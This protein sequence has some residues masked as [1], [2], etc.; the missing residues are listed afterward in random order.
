MDSSVDLEEILNKFIKLIQYFANYDEKLLKHAAVL[1]NSISDRQRD[2]KNA[3]K[4]GRDE[5]TTD[6]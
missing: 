5:L 4:Y 6:I 2:L 1:L 3:L